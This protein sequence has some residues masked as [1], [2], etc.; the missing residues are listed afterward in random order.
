M[1]HED[2]VLFLEAKLRMRDNE[3]SIVKWYIDIFEDGQDTR[4]LAKLY[5]KLKKKH[6]DL[7]LEHTTVKQSLEKKLFNT[8]EQLAE[9]MAKVA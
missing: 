6:Q 9:A 3:L 8:R 7:R 2:R 4:E 5:H 1:T